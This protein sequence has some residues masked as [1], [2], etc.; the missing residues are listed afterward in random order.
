MDVG[1][2]DRTTINW[3]AFTFIANYLSS[4]LCF[5]YAYTHISFQAIFTKQFSSK[6]ILLYKGFLNWRSIYGRTNSPPPLSATLDLVPNNNI[7]FTNEN[8]KTKDKKGN[9]N[10]P[11]NGDELRCHQGLLVTVV[12]KESNGERWRLLG[13][14]VDVNTDAKW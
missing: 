10:I 5:Y 13:N 9:F 14:Y 7:G 4:L 6:T 11:A 3:F 8:T 12:D 1:H 2:D